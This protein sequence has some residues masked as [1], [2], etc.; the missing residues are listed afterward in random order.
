MLRESAVAT[1]ALV[2]SVVVMAPVASAQET[3]PPP[4]TATPPPA[5]TNTEVKP[6]PPPP[7]PPAAAPAPVAPSPTAT[8][9]VYPTQPG[10]ASSHVSSPAVPIMLG[11]GLSV[12]GGFTIAGLTLVLT[13]NDFSDIDAGGVTLFVLGY[14]VGAIIGGVGL[15]LAIGG[16]A[17]A[18]EIETRHPGWAWTAAIASVLGA[19]STIAAVT[20]ALVDDEI[21]DDTVALGIAG[22]AFYLAT[23]LVLVG[24]DKSGS[25]IVGLT[26]VPLPGGGGLAISGRL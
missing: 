1:I 12:L 25:P 9:P 7:P 20:T 5:S 10:P 11:T 8:V 14:A 17:G 19:A 6:E 24:L 18:V 4:S 23:L 26:P 22:G 3:A 16:L 15:Y 13:N 21:G 2:T